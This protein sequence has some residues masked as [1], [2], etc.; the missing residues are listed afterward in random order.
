MKAKKSRIGLALWVGFGLAVVLGSA[1][2]AYAAYFSSHALPGVS[3][4]GDEVTGQTQE[5]LSRNIAERAEQTTVS[6]TLGATSSRYTLAELGIQVDPEAT[7][8][9]A[10]SD[11]ATFGGRLSALTGATEIEVVVT[12]D[13][14]IAQQ[15]GAQLAAQEGRPAIDAVVRLAEDGASYQVEPA[16]SGTS[17][18]VAPLLEAATRAAKTLTSQ[19][20]DIKVEQVEPLVSTAQAQSAAEVAN[21]L[22]G[23][24]I[25]L[26]G[27]VDSHA[28]TS[29]EKADWVTIPVTEAG[30]GSPGFDEAKLTAWVEAVVAATKVEAQPG[31]RNVNSS[32]QVVSTAKQGVKGYQANNAPAITAE[33]IAALQAGSSYSGTLTYDEVEPTYEQRVVAAGSENLAYQ[34]APD[35][36]WIDLNL[37]NNTVTAYV[38]STVVNGPTYIVPGMPGMETPTGKFSVYLKYR[39]QTM[40][41]TNLDG[42]RYEAPNVPW[43]TYFTGPIAFHG[44]P[45]RSSFGWSG[46]GGSHGCV[47]MPSDAAQFIYEW[48]PMGTVVVSHY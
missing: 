1:T 38:G 8:A 4:A 36:K 15:V 42:S 33:L 28:P 14:S 37:S 26:N 3:V 29:A 6:L 47:N 44:A 46:P 12:Q 32:G 25:T 2:A 11:N 18:D 31:V 9:A 45:W 17:V 5:E 43:V 20:A 7:A 23:L 48:A 30:L 24:E 16:Q 10:F 22:V 13:D 35:E 39:T 34:A 21:A 40:R 19:A 27:R 41:G